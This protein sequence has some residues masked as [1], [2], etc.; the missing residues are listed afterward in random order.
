[1]RKPISK[2]LK[3]IGS[4][5]A[6]IE[7]S[8]DRIARRL[9]ERSAAAD[10]SYRPVFDHLHAELTVVEPELCGLQRVC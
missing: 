8:R 9:V 10:T 7:A 5:R 3:S 4:L 1:M 6:A 2:L